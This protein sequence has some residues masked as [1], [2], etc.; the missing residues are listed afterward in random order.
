MITQNILNILIKNNLTIE[1]ELNFG[2]RLSLEHLLFSEGSALIRENLD[3]KWTVNPDFNRVY[4]SYSIKFYYPKSWYNFTVY[5]NGFNITYDII[6]N[7]T[8]NFIF[9]SNPGNR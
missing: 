9:L 6:I 1:L 4:S 8:A 7:K 3:N 2:Y 5:K